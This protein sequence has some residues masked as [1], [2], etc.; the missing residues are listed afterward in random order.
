[1]KRLL[2]IIFLSVGIGHLTA[3][4]FT[5]L[6][7]QYGDNGDFSRMDSVYSLAS[8][9]INYTN[10]PVSALDMNV[11]YATYLNSQ[12]KYDEAYQVL[13]RAREEAIRLKKE[14]KYTADTQ[15]Q[16]QLSE[17][18]ATYETAYG[19]W[20]SNKLYE[21]N[22]FTDE[23]IDLFIQI[24]DTARL[25]ESYNLSGVIHKN[26]FMLDKAILMYKKAL[27][28]TE[29]QKDY[30]LSAIII[31]N[32]A[33][34]Y[35]ELEET[36][37]AIIFSRRI[38]SYP[39][40]DTLAF[41]DQINKISYLCNHAILL[42]NG[43]YYQNALDS[44]Q[45]ATSLLQENMPAGLKLYIYTNYAKALYDTGDS[46]SAINYYQKAISYKKQTSNEYNKANLDYLYGYMLFQATD[47]LQKAH[48]YLTEALAFY[49]KN[50]SIMLTK[51]L[52]AMAEVE[53]KRNHA[54]NSYQLALEAYKTEQ[55]IQHKSF[56][57]RLAGF[58]AE[59]ETKE[60]D[61]E[62]IS[63]NA[64]QAKNK[65]AYQT[66]TYISTSIFILTS[67]PQLSSSASFLRLN[68]LSSLN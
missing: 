43:E 17:G 14:K 22:K 55:K 7:Q 4:D 59:L 25:A 65:A 30:T 13:K 20:A 8:K 49:R 26:L 16:I 44:L 57:D 33:A 3:S 31:S 60:K 1:M 27:K 50:P 24:K 42:T 9:Q 52:L 38:F 28:I 6:I 53:A 68:V 67:N 23:A 46:R 29:Y 19:L 34:L 61:L 39:Q 41:N 10:E 62:I 32:I 12:R 36:Q 5:Q 58:E 64:E 11:T 40:A 63:L 15:K 37:K 18:I 35:N 21:A 48:D 51:S 54:Q 47:S 66:R 2:F 56:H 45:L